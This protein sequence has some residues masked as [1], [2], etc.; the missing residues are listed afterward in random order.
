MRR[1]I[2]VTVGEEEE[3]VMSRQQQQ[4]LDSSSSQADISPQSTPMK[5]TVTSRPTSSTPH[6]HT[7]HQ[8]QQVLVIQRRIKSFFEPQ[9][10]TALCHK[11]SIIYPKG[12]K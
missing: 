3:D 4:Q 2:C 6:K 9:T 7:T 10:W 5:I 8:Q 11:K 12:L 1:V